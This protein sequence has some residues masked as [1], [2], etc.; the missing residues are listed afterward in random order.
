MML[1]H[2]FAFPSTTIKS[3]SARAKEADCREANVT[4]KKKMSSAIKLISSIK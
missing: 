3:R 2:L 4:K 1:I